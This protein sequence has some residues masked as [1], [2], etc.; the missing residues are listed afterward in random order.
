M[1]IDPMCLD[2]LACSFVWSSVW[3]GLAM[4]IRRCKAT[5]GHIK[6]LKA[7]VRPYIRRNQAFKV[8]L[9]SCLR[10]GSEETPATGSNCEQPAQHLQQ[11]PTA[12]IHALRHRVLAIIVLT[13]LGVQANSTSL[14]PIAHK[15]AEAAGS[16]LVRRRDPAG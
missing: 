6:G 16:D 14:V 4:D 3:R 10:S 8:W 2:T 5:S 7:S 15:I 9:L 1:G 11:I 13:S 12:Q